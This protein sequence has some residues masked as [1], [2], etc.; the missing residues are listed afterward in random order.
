MKVKG[1]KKKYSKQENIAGVA[2]PISDKIQFKTEAIKRDTERQF[3]ILKGRNYQEDINIINIYVSN[4]R[5]AKYIRK[6]L[7]DFKKDIDINTLTL[8]EFNTPLST[9]G[10]S[11]KESTRTLWH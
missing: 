7:E 5:S 9:M 4:I 10:R 11:S 6:I 2:I 8:G 1:W 3:K